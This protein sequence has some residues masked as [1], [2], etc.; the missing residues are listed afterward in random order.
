MTVPTLPRVTSGRGCDRA[1]GRPRTLT[2]QPLENQFVISLNA[3]Q[4]FIITK[5]QLFHHEPEAGSN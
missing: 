2:K 1:A 4:N 5:K 3:E